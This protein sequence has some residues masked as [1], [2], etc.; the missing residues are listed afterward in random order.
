MHQVPL[1]AEKNFAGLSPQVRKK[2]DAALQQVEHWF[3]QHPDIRTCAF[4]CQIDES[5]LPSLTMMNT[6]IVRDERWP[7]T[8]E[9]AKLQYD[10]SFDDWNLYR[11]ERR[12]D[13][14][15]TQMS[16][17]IKTL[18]DVVEKGEY[19]EGGAFWM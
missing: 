3:S 19:G 14:S 2:L 12:V 15:L 1:I 6:A 4:I 11:P 9:I 10:V 7:L 16:P 13:W 18:L 5:G 17:S 8:V